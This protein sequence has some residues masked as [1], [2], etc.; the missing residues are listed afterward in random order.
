MAVTVRFPDGT[1]KVLGASVGKSETPPP[2]YSIEQ[3]VRIV[4]RPPRGGRKA[5]ERLLNDI[6]VVIAAASL[7]DRFKLERTGVNAGWL[8]HLASTFDWTS[9]S[10]FRMLDLPKATAHQ[11]IRDAQPLPRTP[12]HAALAMTRLYGEAKQ[13]LHNSTHKDAADFQ[14]A[15]WFSRW[16]DTPNRAL[17]GSKP[18]ELIAD[19]SGVEM[20]SRALGAIESGAYQ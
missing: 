8:V 15:Q 19:P 7:S 6:S 3:V 13:I 2:S 17:G 10:L 16:M 12:S 11:K 1:K 4:S 14:L 5:T 18:S 9:E 20:V